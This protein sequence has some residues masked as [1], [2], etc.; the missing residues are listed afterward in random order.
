[1]ISLSVGAKNFVPEPKVDGSVVYV[2]PLVTPVAEVDLEV[3]EEFC[4]LVFG[5]KRKV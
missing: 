3:L 5:T 4:R 2:E 1:M